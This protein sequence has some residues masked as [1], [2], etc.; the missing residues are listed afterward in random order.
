MNLLIIFLFVACV[1]FILFVAFVAIGA[2]ML[3][4][5]DKLQSQHSI[6]RNFPGIGHIRYL[7]EHV[8]PELRQ[9]FFEDDNK[10]KPFS[11]LDFQSIVKPAKYLK[12]II[13]FGSKKDFEKSSYFIKNA[14]FPKQ[15]SE[16]KVDNDNL[17]STK[18]YIVDKDG[19]F[20][21]KE[22]L[23]DTSVKPWLLHDDDAIVIGENT[24]TYPFKVKGLIGMSAMS[25][26][27]LGENAISAL[28]YGLANATGTWMNTGEGGVSPHHLKGNVD[29]IAQIG[30]GIFGYRDK[31][32]NFS[33]EELKKKAETPQIKAFEIKLGQGAKIRGGHVEAAKVSPEIA[34]IRGVEPYKTI[35]SPNRFNQFH[36]IPSLMEFV[37]KIRE[38]TGKPVGIK[39]VVGGIDSV[40]ELADYIRNTGNHP[41]FITV[42]GGE[43]GTGATYQS[44]SD[45]VGLPLKSAL[46]IL[47][48]TLT[49]YGVRDKVKIIASGK[50]FSSDRIAIALGMGADLTQVA[51]G[52]MISVGCIGA[53]RCHSND[54]PVG[55]A[56][57]NPKLQQALVIDE[58]KYRVTNYIITLREDLYA[59]AAAAGLSSPAQ[60]NDSHISYKDEQGKVKKLKEIQQMD[61]YF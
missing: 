17:V 23:T 45:S 16:L 29:I 9:Y 4:R 2:F 30:P 27:A 13:A 8:G 15:L 58:K 31:A 12:S 10:G 19:L 42:D 56:T 5:H 34:E 3:I 46:M 32:G 53:Q 60:F 35:D 7:L 55:V 25:Y 24:C 49:K 48:Q 1:L 54:C 11:R 43:G 61:N 28:S 22:H 14:F 26:G 44:M 20:H 6:L 50:L 36:D 41:D 51:R 52:L 47:H 33:W 21:R 38:H 37:L 40:E 57:T 59:L 39:I 18:K